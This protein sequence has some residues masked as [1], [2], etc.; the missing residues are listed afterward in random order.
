[1]SS[2]NI[3]FVSSRES[4]ENMVLIFYREQP[5]CLS[6][7]LTYS[8]GDISVSELYVVQA[9]AAFSAVILTLVC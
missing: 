2:R 8:S 4:R 5:M 3:L 9:A 6:T 7:T 1:M